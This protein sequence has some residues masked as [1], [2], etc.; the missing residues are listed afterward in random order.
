ML[1]NTLLK[2]L[3]WLSWDLSHPNTRYNPNS[4]YIYLEKLEVNSNDQ[5]SQP[6]RFYGSLPFYLTRDN[7]VC[8]F[9]DDGKNNEDSKNN[10]AGDDLKIVPLNKRTMIS[11]CVIDLA[12]AYL[13]HKIEQKVNQDIK[14]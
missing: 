12:L 11:V 14:T 8:F 10:Q 6:L 7:F 13:I 9:S 3:F 5:K 2:T 4:R 1:I